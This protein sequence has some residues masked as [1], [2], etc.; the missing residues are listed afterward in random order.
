MVWMEK[1]FCTGEKPPCNYGNS[2]LELD[3]APRLSGGRLGLGLEN[4][5]G[6]AVCTHDN[7]ATSPQLRG[8]EAQCRNCVTC[9]TS[10]QMCGRRNCDTCAAPPQM[11][12]REGQCRNCVRLEPGLEPVRNAWPEDKQD[13]PII[14]VR[15]RNGINI[16]PYRT[17]HSDITTHL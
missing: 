12:G 14:G 15:V 5:W 6:F 11:C 7:E 1:D 8:R 10:P 3:V 2:C 16:A 4:V 13:H 17:P 9:A